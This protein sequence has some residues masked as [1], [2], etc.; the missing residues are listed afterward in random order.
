MLTHLSHAHRLDTTSQQGN[1]TGYDG[2]SPY[3]DVCTLGSFGQENVKIM[4]TSGARCG[5]LF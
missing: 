1:D 5:P 4:Y 2:N 3:Y